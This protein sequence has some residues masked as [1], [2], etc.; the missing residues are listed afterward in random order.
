M[1]AIKP[2]NVLFIK[3]GTG[4]QYETDCIEK[5]QNLRL[6]YYGVVHDI[7]LNGKWDEVHKYFTEVEKAKTFVASNHTNQIK[8]FYEEDENTLWITFYKNKLWW[9]FSRPEVKL[10]EDKSKVRPV[11]GKWSDKDVN[12]NTLYAGN[13]SGKLLKTQGYRGTICSV[14]EKEY[15]L[16]KIN[17][18]QVKEVVD[19]ENALGN[20]KE[21]LTLLIQHLQWKDFETLVDLI[22]RQAGWQRVGVIGKAQKTIDLELLAPVT[23]ERAIVQIKSQS[24]IKEFQYYE[25]KFAEMNDYDKSFFVTRWTKNLWITK[26]KRR[27]ICTQ[28]IKLRI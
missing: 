10:L 1:T 2:Q 28:Q 3:L 8:Q 22:F 19:V 4:G 14:A 11:I 26:V 15:A 23:G 20:L 16:A 13:I 6:G 27:L 17:C 5:N 12:G 24:N 21:K 25:K 7:C 9:C 18:K